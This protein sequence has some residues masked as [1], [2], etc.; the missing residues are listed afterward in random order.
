MF[1]P[2]PV[3]SLAIKPIRYW[4]TQLLDLS[5][6]QPLPEGRPYDQGP[7]DHESKESRLLFPGQ[8]SFHLKL[9]P[10]SL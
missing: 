2:D 1:V 5:R 9:L 6:T 7:R 8:A 10:F 3:I 4:D